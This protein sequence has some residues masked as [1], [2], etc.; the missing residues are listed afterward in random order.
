MPLDPWVVGTLTGLITT[1][2]LSDWSTS[3]SKFWS[4]TSASS[5]IEI[6]FSPRVWLA[7]DGR[8][9]LRPVPVLCLC[10]T[11]E[12]LVAGRQPSGHAAPHDRY[13]LDAGAHPTCREPKARVR[14]RSDH[15]PCL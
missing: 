7:L 13:L 10:S 4:L 11:A 1:T 12:R 8:G 15:D 14:I 3:A 6:W 9:R 5:A 2:G